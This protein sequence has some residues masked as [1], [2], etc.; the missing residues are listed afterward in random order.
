M[1]HLIYKYHLAKIRRLLDLFDRNYSLGRSPE[2]ANYMDEVMG[3][4]QTM[5]N[6]VRPIAEFVALHPDLTFTLVEENPDYPNHHYV[7]TKKDR[8]FDFTYQQ[9]INVRDLLL[10]QGLFWFQVKYE[11]NGAIDWDSRFD[12]PD[13]LLEVRAETAD[14]WRVKRSENDTNLYF[15]TPVG[16]KT[17]EEA[18]RIGNRLKRYYPYANFSVFYGDP[19]VRFNATGVDPLPE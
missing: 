15:L 10:S 12:R 8:A 9:A 6:Q 14:L 13:L 3:L 1:I 7:V 2:L 4:I 18:Q 16:E 17:K 19:P 11:E 5:R